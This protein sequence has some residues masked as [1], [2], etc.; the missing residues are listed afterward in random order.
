MP[1]DVGP[2]S[3][4][5]VPGGV[6]Q[7]RQRAFSSG[8]ELD[9]VIAQLLQ[10]IRYQA[11]HEPIHRRPLPPRACF[12][13]PDQRRMDFT[14]DTAPSYFNAKAPTDTGAGTNGKAR[15]EAGL[16]ARR[17]LPRPGGA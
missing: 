16:G 1:V 15:Q 3:A 7:L 5:G 10:G 9:L 17:A 6:P 2:M 4:L 12:Q 14:E 13:G 11:L 8:G